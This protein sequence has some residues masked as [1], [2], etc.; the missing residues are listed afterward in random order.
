MFWPLIAASI[1]FLVV[2]S[3]RVIGDLHGPGRVV[4]NSLMIVTWVMFGVDYVV[5]FALADARARW[6]RTHLFDL[7]CVILPM[8]RALRLLRATTR[9]PWMRRTAG[10]ALRSR[11]AIYGAGAVVILI[12]ITSLGEL[13]AERHAPGANIVTFGDAVWWSFVTIATVGYGDFYPVTVFGRVVA[14][15]LMMGGVAVV[16]SVT[17]TLA[18]WIVEVT[19]RRSGDDSHEPAT[20][21]DM[22]DV[23]TQLAELSRRL[24]E[25]GD[26]P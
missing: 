5:R 4:I 18:S 26:P 9:I 13:D 25:P 1:V 10:G 23:R 19:A 16:G 11:I 22:R 8:F 20:R 7:L 21:A 3:W 12:W 17:A 14:V 2:Y 15:L 24:G 6:F